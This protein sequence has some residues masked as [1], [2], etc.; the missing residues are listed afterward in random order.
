MGK[1]ME[2]Y[3][4]VRRADAPPQFLAVSK[5]DGHEF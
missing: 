1:E 3:G 5:Q 4:V 2:R